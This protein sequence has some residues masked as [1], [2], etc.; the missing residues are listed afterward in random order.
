MAESHCQLGRYGDSSMGKQAIGHSAV[1]QCRYD[2]SMQKPG[3]STEAIL[4][5]KRSL[6]AAILGGLKLHTK[7]MGNL[8][9]AY[10]TMPMCLLTGF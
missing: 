3:V 1:K 7:P 9:A 6:N 10:Y 4:A 2:A 8:W 5:E